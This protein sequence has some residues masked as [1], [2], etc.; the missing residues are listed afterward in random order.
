MI[1]THCSAFHIVLCSCKHQDGITSDEDGYSYL[2][3]LARIVVMEL[4]AKGILQTFPPREDWLSKLKLLKYFYFGKQ[5]CV[6][7]LLN[8][9]DN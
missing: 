3:L 9:H 2:P 4:V 5:M 6:S 1:K 8:F 7:S